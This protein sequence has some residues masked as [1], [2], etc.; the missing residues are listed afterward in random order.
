MM[1]F[2]TE[3]TCCCAVISGDH[4]LVLL[5]AIPHG[6]SRM[7]PGLINIGMTPD[8]ISAG[9]SR[10]VSCGEFIASD[11]IFGASFHDSDPSPLPVS[12]SSQLARNNF[13]ISSSSS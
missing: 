8:C 6:L 1:L 2:T 7:D 12:A 13:C 11:F 3:S 10:S 9:H 5:N 4:L